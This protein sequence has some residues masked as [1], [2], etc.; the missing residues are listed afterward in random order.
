MSALILKICMSLNSFNPN[1]LDCKTMLAIATIESSLNA[2]AIGSSHGE[3]GLF[4]LRPVF[5]KCA[6]KDPAVNIRCAYGY[7]SELKRRFSKQHGNC[8]ISYYNYGPS[9]GL[10]KPCKTDYYKKVTKV[11]SKLADKLEVGYAKR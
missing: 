1:P 7:L 5:H 3:V 6:K 8:F 9:S 10:K 4:Q 2:D 11:K